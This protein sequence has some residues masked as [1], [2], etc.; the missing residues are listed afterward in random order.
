MFLFVER[1]KKMLEA[2]QHKMFFIYARFIIEQ[3]AAFHLSL[4]TR[5][6]VNWM[7]YFIL[8]ICTLS[9]TC[10]QICGRESEKKTKRGVKKVDFILFSQ[11]ILLVSSYLH[12]C[13]CSWVSFNDNDK[14]R[15][16]FVLSIHAKTLHHENEKCD[17]FSTSTFT[18]TLTL[19]LE[20]SEQ[21][22]KVI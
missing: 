15:K 11:L 19:T 20:E 7:R 9:V 17:E 22:E 21:P 5:I 18:V 3:M 13:M 14:M 10:A 1:E 2:S 4:I 12:I 8:Y 16:N 6:V